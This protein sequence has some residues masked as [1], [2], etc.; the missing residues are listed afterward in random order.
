MTSHAFLRWALAAPV[1]VSVLAITL[2]RVENDLFALMGVALVMGLPPYVA[3]TVGFAAWARDHEPAKVRRA[4]WLAPLLFAFPLAIF[5]IV[6]ILLMMGSAG[7]DVVPFVAIAGL[8]GVG[9]GY[10]FVIPAA[11]LYRLLVRRGAIGA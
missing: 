10:A 9:V 8:V 6:W 2:L 1:I 11:A 3:F 4:A 7:T 5:W